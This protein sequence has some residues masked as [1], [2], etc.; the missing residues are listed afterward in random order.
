MNKLLILTLCWLFLT[1]ICSH[2]SHVYG[3]TPP[4]AASASSAEARRWT[5]QLYSSD[6]AIRSSAA[7]S[8]LGLDSDKELQLLL[9]ILSRS[10]PATRPD[11]S[12]G[13]TAASED[14]V[15]ISIIKAFG[16]RADDRATGPLIERLEDANPEVRESACEAL[17]SLN[18]SEAIQRMSAN[19][20]NPGS[21]RESR[22]LLSQ[23]L[24]QTMGQEAVE[25][26]IT[27]L[28]EAEDSELQQAA[29][30]ALR[31]I[32]QQS[33]GKNPSEWEDWW[34]ANKNKT[35]EQ[36][37][38]DTVAKLELANEELQEK[39]DALERELA[40]KTLSLLQEAA[41]N[42]DQKTVI[43]AT[44]SEYPEVR[45]SA[46]KA[47]TQ[48]DTPETQSAL[49]AALQND[50]EGD[51]RVAATQGLGELGDESALEPLLYALN[52]ED[53]S[54]RENAA[55]ALANFN[56]D[57]VVEALAALLNSSSEPVVIAATEALGQIG[58]ANAVIP[59]SELLNNEKPQAREVAAI[60]LGK[61]KDP[62]AV[63][64]LINSLK[65]PEEKVRWYAA[66]SLGSIGSS[67]G[68]DA[69]VE[70]L[71][72]DS[73][74]VRESAAAAL[75]QIG[76]ERAI[77][78]L[79]QAMGDTDKRV[80]EQAANALLSIDIQSYEAMK[81]LADTFYDR[82]DYLRASQIL[83]NQIARYSNSEAHKSTIH[84]RRLKLAIAYQHEK[85]WKKAA[86]QYE[87]LVYEHK[88]QDLV[89]LQAL[90][91]CLA[92][93]KQYNRILELYSQWMKEIPQHAS[94]WWEGRLDVIYT[95]FENG[96]YEKI[97]RLVDEF[98][99]ED[100]ELGGA[101]LSRQFIELAESSTGKPHAQRGREGTSIVP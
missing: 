38:K 76:D 18:S 13:K 51:V 100:P 43:E 95:L 12:N 50:S 14:E 68:V 81:Y 22:I 3:E 94:K 66:D 5:K 31:Y 71:A 39:N 46:I 28:K 85:D 96:N 29:L 67:E 52:D 60:A 41:D 21:P 101:R 89:I 78:P 1:P 44:K 54:V 7:I 33:Y 27:I 99:L 55:R 20:L 4:G 25:P 8:L 6:P 83:E 32:S 23:A 80:A 73:P 45:V 79:A 47:L 90:V 16:F 11:Q 65:D 58:N 86:E 92:E 93:L 30:E 75:G 17:A 82:E 77:E 35:N 36:W 72:K 10:H 26:L 56:G 37:Q 57:N 70:L 74:R 40:D 24:G 34:A 61:I 59:I 48:L 9:D 62:Q 63:T 97:P 91:E 84:N 53:V 87:M 69:L 15:L 64:P 98:Q 88:L 42:K 2:T 49:I 19:L